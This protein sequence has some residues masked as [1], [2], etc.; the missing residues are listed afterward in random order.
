MYTKCII[1]VLHYSCELF[2]FKSNA[3][4]MVK[5]LVAT[6]VITHRLPTLTASWKVLEN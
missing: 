2:L 4:K 6:T 3:P 5:L 1:N